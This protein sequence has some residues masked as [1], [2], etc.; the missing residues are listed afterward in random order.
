[1]KSRSE[2]AENIKASLE[3]MVRECEVLD[4]PQMRNDFSDTKIYWRRSQKP[5]V[6]TSTAESTLP[7]PTAT[8]ASTSTVVP[9]AE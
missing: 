9:Q 6:A 7:E 5:E 1:M 4:F 8:E 3:D 2:T